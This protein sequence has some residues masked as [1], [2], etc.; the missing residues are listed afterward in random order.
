MNDGVESKR[1]SPEDI[2]QYLENGF[3]VGALYA[4]NN[5]MKWVHNDNVEKLV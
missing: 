1:V 3:K 2:A 4:T 5:G